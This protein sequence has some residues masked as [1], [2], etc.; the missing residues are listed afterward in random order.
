MQECIAAQDQKQLFFAM[1][2][3]PLA[4]KL[5]G[6]GDIHERIRAKREALGLSAEALGQAIGV[7]RQ[8]VQQ[9]EN[10]STAPSRRHLPAV[11][12]ALQCSE[13]FL[14][15]G[16]ASNAPGYS[17]S[18]VAD[19]VRLM[20]EIERELGRTLGDEH[21]SRLV[22]AVADMHAHLDREASQRD[23]DHF[24]AMLVRI[25]TGVEEGLHGL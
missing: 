11:A 10:R 23:R 2:P 15:A 6:M 13:E 14:V 7:S 3:K 5:Q 25:V 4:T 22:V 24:R 19:S 1:P 18:L 16:P 21:F 9:W 8:T 20:R 12:A 17:G